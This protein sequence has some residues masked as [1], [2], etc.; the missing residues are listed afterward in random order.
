MTNKTDRILSELAK[1]SASADRPDAKRM[2]D[3]LPQIEESIARGVSRRKIYQILNEEGFTFTFESF[4]VTLARLRKKSRNG[5]KPAPANQQGAQA[6]PTSISANP[7][8]NLQGIA[9][10][11]EFNPIPQVKFEIAEQSER[12]TNE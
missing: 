2:R 6:P 1:Q 8:K 12:K 3:I 9:R 10:S 7:F 11:G 5:N 4:L